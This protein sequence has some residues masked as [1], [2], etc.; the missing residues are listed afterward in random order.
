MS[1]L[2]NSVYVT[3]PAKI[4][5]LSTKFCQFLV[6]LLYHNLIANYLYYCNKMFIIIVEF[7]GLSSAAYGNE[8]VHSEQKILAKV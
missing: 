6:C 7:N 3:G 5:H 1:P 4:G 8:I 2:S